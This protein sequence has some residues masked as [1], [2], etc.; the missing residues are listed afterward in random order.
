MKDLAII[1]SMSTKEGRPRPGDVQPP[2]GLPAVTGPIHYPTLGSLVAKEF[3]DDSAELPGFVSISPYRA[4]NPAAFSAGF[5]GPKYAPLIVGERA[6]LGR[7]GGRPA[8]AQGG[9]PRPAGRRRP[10]A[11]RRPARPP[12]RAGQRVPGRPGRESRRSSHQDAYERAVKMMRSPAAKA[13]ELEEEPGGDPRRLRPE[14][15]RA[16]VPAR[17]PPGRAERPVR[18]G[19]ALGRRRLDGLRLGH[20]PEELRRRREA[21][22]GARPGL[23]HA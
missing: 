19:D 4:F 8:L 16:G 22:Q 2:D 5:L 20:A 10:R 18:R 14:P 17:P 1:R 23:G 21:Q 9:R 15:V 6:V 3:E 7:P 11:G 12:R 13:F